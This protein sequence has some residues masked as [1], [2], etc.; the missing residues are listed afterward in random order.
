MQES[1][2]PAPRWILH[3]TLLTAAFVLEV[4]LANQ[5]EP[6]GFVRSLVVAS[7]GAAALTLVAWGATR[8]RWLGG[9]IA[10]ALILVAIS[11]GPLGGV[12]QMG[13]DLLGG[14]GAIVLLGLVL[15]AILAVPA[16]LVVRAR[17]GAPL[18]RHRATSA[19][20]LLTAVLRRPGMRW[21]SRY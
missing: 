17:R 21:R 20:N 9:L 8:D 10:T 13:R 7:A 11:L 5:V 2:T 3:P 4:A 12:W 1:P 19:L 14:S 6:P 18:I 15:I 16:Y